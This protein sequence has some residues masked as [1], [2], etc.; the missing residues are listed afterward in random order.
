MKL[1]ETINR[2]VN[3]VAVTITSLAGFAF[4][5]EIFIE[6]KLMYKLDDIALFLMGIISI[7]WYRKGRNNLSR[8]ITP[9]IIVFLSLLIKIGGIILEIKEKDD[10]G[11]DFGGLILF[12]L[13]FSLV[14]YLYKKARAFEDVSFNS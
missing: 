5:P 4:M 9:V 3:L 1:S 7:A 8:T 6:D 2:T 11:D 12:I 14:Y 13:G 10:V